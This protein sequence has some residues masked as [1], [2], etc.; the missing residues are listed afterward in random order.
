MVVLLLFSLVFLLLRERW[1]RIYTQKIA[2]DSKIAIEAK[3]SESQSTTARKY[4]LRH[5]QLPQELGGVPHGPK[6]LD[7]QHVHEANEA[8]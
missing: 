4:E 5:Q 8:F 1:R 7:S 3:R 6:E 2:D